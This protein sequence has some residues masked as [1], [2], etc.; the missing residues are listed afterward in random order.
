M[1]NLDARA[2]IKSKAL[3]IRYRCVSTL[4]PLA[5]ELLCQIEIEHAVGNTG[6]DHRVLSELRTQKPIKASES[7]DYCSSLAMR[8]LVSVLA[9]L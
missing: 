6:F 2:S 5:G 4:L 7:A 9:R 3:N 8:L 1:F